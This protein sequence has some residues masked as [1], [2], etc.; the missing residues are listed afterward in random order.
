[1]SAR[2]ERSLSTII[3]T[4]GLRSGTIPDDLLTKLLTAFKTSETALKTNLKSVY[5]PLQP[6]R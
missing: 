5:L 1:M 2:D 6:S 3:E 4:S